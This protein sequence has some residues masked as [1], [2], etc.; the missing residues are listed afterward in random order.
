M[1]FLASNDSA[2]IATGGLL[3]LLAANG[4]TQSRGLYYG[5][6]LQQALNF[7]ASYAALGMSTNYNGNL[8]TQTMNLKNLVGNSADPSLTTTLLNQAVAAGVDTYPNFNG[9]AKVWTSGINDYFDNQINL[10][11]FATALQI[12]GFNALAQTNT[13]VPQTENGMNILKN[14]L[15]AV[16]EQAVTNGFIAPGAWTSPTTFGN[17]QLFYQNI[18]QRGYYI[19]SQPV[20]QQLPT[21]RALRQAPLIQIAIKY[22]GAIQ[23]GSVVVNVNP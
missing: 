7:M 13:K 3:Q 23:S 12:A 5:G 20:A 17:Q 9:V 4:F 8:T 18:A 2:S 19:Y 22:A 14:A 6:T 21:A 1:L 11:W 16:C 15:R 10:Q